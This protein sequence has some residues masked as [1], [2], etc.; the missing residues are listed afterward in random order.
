MRDGQDDYDYLCLLEKQAARIKALAPA[1][2]LVA[3]AEKILATDWIDSDALKTPA[4]LRAWRRKIADL[5]V[6]MAKEPQ[7]NK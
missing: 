1:N 6:K 7:K 2:P 4:S 5:I 3:E